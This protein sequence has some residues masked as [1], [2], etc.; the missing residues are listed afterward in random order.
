MRSFEGCRLFLIALLLLAAT[1][2]PAKP[3]DNKDF[4]VF[5]SRAF[6]GSLPEY[7]EVEIDASG[8]A[9]YRE[10]PEEEPLEFEV[11]SQDL[12]T[13]LGYVESLE[14][15]RISPAS[16]RKVAFTGDK[17]FRYIDA[18]GKSTETTFNYSE[19]S[20]A[21]ALLIW[22]L[23]VGETERHR[24]ELGRLARFDRLGVNKRLLQFQVSL[25]KGRVISP[26]QMLPILQNISKDKKII[27]LSRS[28]ATALAERI[29]SGIGE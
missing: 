25:D 23:K 17:T 2:H 9:R 29:E 22:F 1:V 21:H 10:D 18:T 11:T 15:F 24:I 12:A 20:D 4:R 16:S 8:T 26:K 3:A 14:Y 7:F 27:H 28:R 5:F 19:N 6:P 13:M